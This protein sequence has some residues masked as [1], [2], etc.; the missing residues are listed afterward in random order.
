MQQP[1]VAW[2][3]LISVCAQPLHA[4]VGQRCYDAGYWLII[5]I[6]SFIHSSIHSF[7][8]CSFVR[9]SNRPSA[10]PSVCPSVLVS[11]CLSVVCL[12]VFFFFFFFFC[13][14]LCCLCVC[15]LFVKTKYYIYLTHLCCRATQKKTATPWHVW[16][17][18]TWWLWYFIV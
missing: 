6:Y 13:F 4:E 18:K 2:L 1:N 9:P 3:V 16:W 7:V 5:Y 11:D 15:C 17:Y 14:F 8:R 10:C 12:L